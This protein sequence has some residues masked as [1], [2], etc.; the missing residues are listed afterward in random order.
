MPAVAAAVVI[1]FLL[2]PLAAM[3]GWLVGQGQ[4]K[5]RARRR[6]S[7]SSRYFRGLNYLLNEESDKAIE[8]FL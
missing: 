6:S 1:L 8:E 5:Q 3:S 2:L 4:R 7:L